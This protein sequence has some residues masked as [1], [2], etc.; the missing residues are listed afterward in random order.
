MTDLN[1]KLLSVFNRA[2]RC[3]LSEGNFTPDDIPEWDSLTHIKL[4]ME[5]ESAFGVVIGPDDILQLYSD[6]NTVAGFI[7]QATAEA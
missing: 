4:V 7:T 1:E 2:L 6:F 3:Q 5:L